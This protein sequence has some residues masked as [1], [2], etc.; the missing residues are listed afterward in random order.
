MSQAVRQAT[1]MRLYP[2]AAQEAILRQW[3]GAARYVWNQ[4]VAHNKAKYAVEGKFD[5]HT[6]LSA[7]LPKWKLDPE[8]LWLGEPPAISL[9]D[10]S[11]R[12]DAALAKALKDRK[13]GNGN[14]TAGFPTFHKKREGY[15]SLYLTGQGLMLERQEDGK[16]RGWLI[17]PK[18]AGRI[19][20]HGGL[21]PD[22]RIASAR[23][24]QAAGIWTVSIQFDG[25]VRPHPQHETER[26]GIDLGL[27][28]LVALP[29]GSKV[30]APRLYREASCALARLQ[31]RF[32]KQQTREEK[33][34]KSAKD[35]SARQKAK[36]KRIT[37]LH[38]KVAA[39]RKDFTHK[40]SHEL[41]AKARVI[42]METLGV[43]SLARTRLAKSVY[44]AAWGEL[45]RQIEYKAAWRGGT[46]LKMG[47]FER[48]SGCCPDCGHVGQKLALAERRWTCAVCGVVHDRDTAAARWIERYAHAAEVPAEA[49]TGRPLQRGLGLRRKAPGRTANVEIS[50]QVCLGV[51]SK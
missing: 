25:A 4:F 47:R 15:G 26:L 29:D 2:N 45:I 32:G 14:R 1:V 6:Q 31:R 37:A 27:D 24:R 16:A 41:T 28:A 11:R 48:S 49:G 9:V 42:A 17:L 50:A 23:I 10:V 22:G 5:F 43:G 36:L 38:R 34:G 3:T 46:V 13:K 51:E 44:D 19:K 33:A 7:L 18:G 21:W 35:R 30:E 20:M 8:R 40:L 12:Y 39:Q